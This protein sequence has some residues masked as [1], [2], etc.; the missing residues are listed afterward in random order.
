MTQ[1]KTAP[2]R[3]TTAS[4]TITAAESN[5]VR[6]PQSVVVDLGLPS[7]VEWSDAGY[8]PARPEVFLSPVARKAVKRLSVTLDVNGAKLADGTLV[9]GHCS[10]TIA[11]LC[12]R[13]A[14]A[15]D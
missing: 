10:K 14:D 2:K 8:L 4:R 3:R 13:L 6:Q 7:L 11:W 9:R 5:G 12:E 1:N 15:V